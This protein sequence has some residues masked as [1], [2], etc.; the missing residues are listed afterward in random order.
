MNVHLTEKLKTY[1]QQKVSSGRYNSASEV[2]RA[3]LRLLQDQDELRAVKLEAFRRSVHEATEQLQR[4][5]GRD[6]ESVF[7]A[8]LAGLDESS[9]S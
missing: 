7:S 1:V 5:E 9:G 8:L 6:G 2:V 4:G 3:G